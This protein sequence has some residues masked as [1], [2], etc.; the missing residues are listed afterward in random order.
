MITW[1]THI[2]SCHYVLNPPPSPHTFQ[3]LIPKIISYYPLPLS[4][5][6]PLFRN[7]IIPGDRDK[8]WPIC[9]STWFPKENRTRLVPSL[10]V[11][12]I[13]YIIPPHRFSVYTPLFRNYMISYI[14]RYAYYM[15]PPPHFSVYAAVWGIQNPTDISVGNGNIPSARALSNVDL[16][17]PGGEFIDCRIVRFIP[18]GIEQCGE[19]MWNDRI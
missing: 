2:L 17:Q 8:S 12:A 4:V 9:Y 7:Y 1:V 19:S 6:T 11:N 16:P 10:Y 14:L 3:I 18:K 13:S 5:Y 15:H